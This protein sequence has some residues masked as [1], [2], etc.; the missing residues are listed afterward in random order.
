MQIKVST[1]AMSHLN[2]SEQNGSCAM[3][4]K[5]PVQIGVCSAFGR[6]DCRIDYRYISDLI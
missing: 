6:I 1:L 3:V 4:L 2:S 5:T